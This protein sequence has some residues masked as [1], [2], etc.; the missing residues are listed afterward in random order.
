C[1]TVLKAKVSLLFPQNSSAAGG[2][3]RERK[4]G[5]PLKESS[6][7]KPVAKKPATQAKVPF[8]KGFSPMDW[9]KL[10]R[11][12]PDLAGRSPRME[13]MPESVRSSLGHSKSTK[14]SSNSDALLRWKCK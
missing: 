11:T 13:E 3:S 8:E 14:G 12:H 5:K 7:L 10:T 1:S 4:R 9:V 6:E 2:V